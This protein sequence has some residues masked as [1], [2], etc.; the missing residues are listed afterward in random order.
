MFIIHQSKI[1][2][3]HICRGFALFDINFF[4]ILKNIHWNFQ[5]GEIFRKRTENTWSPQ[6]N[7]QI[8][9]KVTFFIY[10]N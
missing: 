5:L 8:V 9:D 4:C 3:S 1:V 7:M 10:Q 2:F 6:V